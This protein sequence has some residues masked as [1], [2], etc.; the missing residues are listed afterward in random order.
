VLNSHT[1]LLGALA[2][3]GLA[4]LLRQ[5]GVPPAVTATT[6][7]LMACFAAFP[8]DLVWRGP[9]LPYVTGVALVPAFLLLVSALVRDPGT[10]TVVLVGLGGA[11]LFGLQ[12]ATALFAAVFALL[13]LAQRWLGARRVPWGELR[14]LSL[15]GA[16]VLLLS[17]PAI[18]GSVRAGAGG[19][20]VDWATEGTGWQVVGRLLLLG[21]EGSGPQVWL[22][23]LVAAGVVGLR[24]ARPLWWWAAGTAVAVLLF[25]LAAASD[26]ALAAALT[27]PWW[28]DAWRLLGVAALGMAP[29]AAH[30]AWELAR[31]LA[32]RTARPAAVAAVLAGVV[33]LT[34][35]LYTPGNTGRVASAYQSDRHLDADEVAAMAWLGRRVPP[36]EVV[37]ND[38]RDGSPFMAALEGIRPVFGHQVPKAT[39]ATLGPTRRTLLDRFHCLD[40]DPDVRSAIEQLGIRYVFLGSGYVRPHAHRAQ[41]LV[42]LSDSPSL[43]LVYAHGGV[44]I[45]RIDLQPLSDQPI[46]ACSDPAAEDPPS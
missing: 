11:A 17:A 2:A 20:S 6:P 45:Y 13:M 3:G 35:G 21:H 38:P 19:G 36:G 40:S 27:R 23:V 37:M 30:G 46:P 7:V 33:V 10:G 41:G 31:L 5:L 4:V 42:G 12:P 39:Y 9:L 24:T 32:R 28:N 26:E 29:L 14:A 8:Y 25:V 44:R 34:G 22:A 18:V 43:D 1:A 15:A 16:L